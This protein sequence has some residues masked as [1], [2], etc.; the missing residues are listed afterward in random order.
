M[1]FGQA[2]SEIAAT[3]RTLAFVALIAANIIIGAMAALKDGK[4]ELAE[5]AGIFDKKLLTLALGFLGVNIA[6][7]GIGGAEGTAVALGGSAV[8]SAPF[9]ASI[10]KYLWLLLGGTPPRIVAGPPK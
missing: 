4:F 2:F 1:D 6:G 5:L 10:L 9:A 3:N 8:A 7:E